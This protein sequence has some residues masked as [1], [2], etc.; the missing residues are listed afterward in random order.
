MFQRFTLSLCASV[1]LDPQNTLCFLPTS[2]FFL[3]FQKSL[4]GR[5]LWLTLH[6][7]WRHTKKHHNRY[8]IK[9]SVKR[10]RCS[11]GAVISIFYTFAV[12]KHQLLKE[13]NCWGPVW[14]PET[15]AYKAPSFIHTSE[16]GMEPALEICFL[17][18]YY[19]CYYVFLSG[20]FLSC[21]YL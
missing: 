18:N 13:F 20:G 11:S 7:L 16:L 5:H 12:M 10:Q 9:N 21:L 1:C 19:Y 8:F 6:A 4:L 3:P 14:T 15:T 2:S 17:L